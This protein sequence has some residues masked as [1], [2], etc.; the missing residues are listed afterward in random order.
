MVVEAQLGVKIPRN[1]RITMHP[2]TEYFKGLRML[3]LLDTFSA[4]KQWM[5]FCAIF[6]LSLWVLGVK[7]CKRRGRLHDG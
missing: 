5:L 3:R 7:W 2:F 4:K 6:K 1:V